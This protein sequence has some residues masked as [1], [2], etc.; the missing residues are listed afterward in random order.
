M[1][2][3]EASEAQIKSLSFTSARE[4]QASMNHRD[5][6]RGERFFRRAVV[7]DGDNAQASN[8]LANALLKL[9]DVSSAQRWAN[10]AVSVAPRDPAARVILGDVLFQKGDRGAAE[11]EW[12]EALQIDPTNFLAKLRMNKLAN[13]R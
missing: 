8:G 7:L 4:A 3:E 1:H 6:A 11:V 12:R 2:L 9:G 10:H 13:T 5:F